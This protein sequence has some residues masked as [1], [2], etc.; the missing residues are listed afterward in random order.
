MGDY[1][2]DGTGER[3]AEVER[4]EGLLRDFAHRPRP[5]EL[6]AGAA[7]E[8]LKG[9]GRRFFAPA[10]L[11]AAAALLLACVLVAAV[12]LRARV[13]TEGNGVASRPTPQA[14]TDEREQTVRAE[15]LKQT[16]PTP[17]VSASH[18]PK[19][20]STPGAAK[21]KSAGAVEVAG[22]P[23]RQKGL[24]SASARV[25]TTHAPPAEARAGGAFTLE[26][27]RAGQGTN[28]LVETTRLLTKEQLVYALRLTGAKLR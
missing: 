22:A 2:W 21:V 13:T 27:M 1:L 5:L 15:E 25:S 23:R 24:Q 10:W 26:A 6:P 9:G 4:L 20:G 8:T 28:S 14:Q 17:N 7:P 16:T 11:A 3:D 18:L 12:Y 19:P